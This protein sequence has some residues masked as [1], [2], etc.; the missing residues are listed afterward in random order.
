M[1]EHAA[2]PSPADLL[3]P[4]LNFIIFVAVLIRYLR[5]PIREYFR[6]R[7]ERLRD[8]LAAGSRARAEAEALRATLAQDIKNLPAVTGQLRADLRATAERERDSILAL[9]RQAADRIRSDAH[10][11]ADHEVAGARTALRAEVIE[12]TIR[13]AT[14]LIRG[15]IRPE[16]QERFVRDFVHSAGEPA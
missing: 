15:A 4:T 9:A 6:A 16:D 7:T 12:E 1:S 13:E 8:G 3:W 2:A 10:A 5:G 11:L 14:A